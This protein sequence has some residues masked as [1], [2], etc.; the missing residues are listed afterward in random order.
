MEIARVL[1]MS[2]CVRWDGAR[3]S[4]ES[5]ISL[6]EVLVGATILSLGLIGMVITLLNSQDLGRSNEETARG[7]EALRLVVERME[8]VNKTDLFSIFNGDPSD[9]PGGAGTAP[10]DTFP[11][12]TEAGDF[13][14]QIEFPVQADPAILREDTTDAVLGMPRDLDG[15]GVVDALD[16]AA[17]YVQLPARVRVTWNGVNGT[18]SLELCTIFLNR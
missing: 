1:Q 4:R 8:G 13:F 15:D 11:L 6:I 3:E 12:Q 2:R 7:A 9:D 16:H 10:G 17:D 18:R 5:G 14:V